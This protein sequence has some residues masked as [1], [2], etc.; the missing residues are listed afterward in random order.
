[1]EHMKHLLWCVV[2]KEVLTL[3]YFM[4]LVAAEVY[5]IISNIYP[6]LFEFICPAVLHDKNHIKE[7]W[8]C[9]CD[10]MQNDSGNK[11]IWLGDEQRGRRD[12]EKKSKRIWIKPFNQ[13]RPTHQTTSICKTHISESVQDL[14]ARIKEKIK[15]AELLQ[16][17]GITKYPILLLLSVSVSLLF[18]KLQV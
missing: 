3:R 17:N 13:T 7:M 8:F 10:W 12:E 11:Q 4:A 2:L 5:Y 15:L 18:P 9:I 6:G 16:N 14:Q 1:M